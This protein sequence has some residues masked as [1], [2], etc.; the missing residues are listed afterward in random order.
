MFPCGVLLVGHAP[1]GRWQIQTFI[2]ALR[3]NRRDA[4][5]VIGGAMNRELSDL[6]VE[7][8]LA[9]GLQQGGVVTLDNLAT[10]RRPKAAAILKVIDAWILFLPPYR[11]DPNPIEMD[12]AKLKTLIR[13]SARTCDQL[14]KAVGKICNLFKQE[15]CY[16]LFKAAGYATDGTQTALD[17]MCG[18]AF[19]ALERQLVQQDS[20]VNVVALISLQHNPVQARQ[21]SSGPR[22]RG[23]RSGPNYSAVRSGG[24]DLVKRGLAGSS[25]VRMIAS[26]FTPTSTT[27]PLVNLPNN[28]SSASGFLMCS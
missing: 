9:P 4:P 28:S 17:P 2:A 14:C 10:H 1:F 16:T 6:C 12:F 3:H 26:S 27:P 21:K 22:L 23:D 24:L 19:G 7:T 25:I 13:N 8:Q 20:D 18:A 11:P 15:E 5:W